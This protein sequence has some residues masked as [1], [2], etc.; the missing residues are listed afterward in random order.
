MHMPVV[1]LGM[2]VLALTHLPAAIPAATGEAQEIF[3][4]DTIRHRAGEVTGPDKQKAPVGTLELVAGRQGQAVQFNFT[5]SWGPGFFI[6][7]L[8]PSPAWDQAGGFSFWL[9][10]DGSTNWGG[11]EL[12]DANNYA[13]RYGYCFPLDSREWRKII[14]PWRDLIPELAGP[15]VAPDNGYA[16]SGF[17]NFW[18]GRWH[19]WREYPPISF[20][21]DQVIL[22]K[23]MPAEFTAIPAGGPGLRRVKSKLAQKRPITLVTM[24]DSLSDKR[25]WANKTRLWSESLAQLLNTKYGSQVTLVNPAIGGTTLSQNLVLMPRWG[26]N[27]PAPDLVTIWFGFND[28]DSGVRGARFKEYLLL[29]VERIRRQTRGQADIV[30]LTTCPAFG[31][32]DTMKE[33]EEAARQ[34][35]REANVGL[36]DVAAA[37]RQAGSA[38]E[39]LKQGYWAW[40]KVHLGAKGHAV[41]AEI[42]IQAIE[43]AGQPPQNP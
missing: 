35:A 43:A 12:I 10:G 8:K 1:T 30:L 37:F 41:A 31:Q 34:V 13:L 27:H 21:V 25:H 6:A 19:Y 32:W 15:P 29:A 5:N 2:F 4:M 14:V 23:T 26:R 18:F 16:P 20:T 28:W 3:S 11:L 7:S 40:D 42:V 36:A 17:G 38:E 24:G 33:M 22:E 39:A 9:K